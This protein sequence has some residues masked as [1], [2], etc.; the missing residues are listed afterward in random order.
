MQIGKIRDYYGYIK[1]LLWLFKA[2]DR[3]L[4]KWSVFII[5]NRSVK[6]YLIK[7]N[8]YDFRFIEFQ[9]ILPKLILF[10]QNMELHLEFGKLF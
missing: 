2:I 1:S 8:A 9:M 10:L 5:R 6:S 4:I 7:I 3:I